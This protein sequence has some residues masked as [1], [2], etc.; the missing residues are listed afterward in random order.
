M[1]KQKLKEEWLKEEKNAPIK[2]WDFSHIGGRYEEETDLP[3]DYER[4][5]RK[6]LKPEY[7]LL[8]IDTGGAEF[9]LSLGHPY[10]N[11]S[12]SENY[13]PNV[14][15]VRTGY[16]HLALILDRVMAWIFYLSRVKVLISSST[17]MAILM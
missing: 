7:K 2:G 8:D 1:N 5:V 17:G 11:T 16:C 10:K 9:L 6:Y 12:A 14:G 15:F 13:Q 4:V 3:W